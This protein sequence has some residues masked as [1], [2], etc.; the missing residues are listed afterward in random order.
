MKR[1]AVYTA[2]FA[3]CALAVIFYYSSHKVVVVEN[4]AQDEVVQNE[5]LQNEE[6]QNTPEEESTVHQDMPA[7]IM[8]ENSILFEEK[9]QEMSYFCIPLH[10]NVRAENVTIENHYMDK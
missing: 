4:V 1:T 6:L 7:D 2:L 5:D 3:V 8:P 9:G 10:S